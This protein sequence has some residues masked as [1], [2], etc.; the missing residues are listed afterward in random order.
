MMLVVIS[1][2]EAG[3]ERNHPAEIVGARIVAVDEVLIA[4]PVRQI[5]SEGE[6]LER[7]EKRRQSPKQKQVD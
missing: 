1:E 4:R 5:G 6:Q 7:R 3:Q 2:M